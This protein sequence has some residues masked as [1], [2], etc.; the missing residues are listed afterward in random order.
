MI[1]VPTD[2]TP[3]ERELLKELEVGRRE[4]AKS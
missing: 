1:T 2:L 3:R 4:P